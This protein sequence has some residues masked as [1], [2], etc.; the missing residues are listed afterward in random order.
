MSER[1]V[2]DPRSALQALLDVMQKLRAPSC[3]CPWDLQQT[4]ASIAPYTLE[5]AYEVVDAIQSGDPATLRDELGDLLFQVVFHARLAEEKRWFDFADVAQGVADKL[6]RRHPHVFAAT[7]AGN[8]AALNSAWEAAKAEERSA[9]GD[10]GVLAGVAKSLPALTRAQKLG[11]RASRV[12]FDWQD[13]SG[14][15]A[16]ITEELAELQAA[17]QSGEAA[18]RRSEEFGDLLFALTSYARHLGVDSEQ[19][20]AAASRKF[21]QRFALMEE[22]ARDRQLQL[23]A[24][25]P[26]QWDQ[27]WNESKVLLSSQSSAKNTTA[28][29]AAGTFS[30][31]SLPG[32]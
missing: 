10:G 18:E 15:H 25:T 4:F 31:D 27:L 8:Q 32:R 6:T 13:P 17:V 24:L 21:E 9:R 30:V 7:A 23:A 28:K 1:I 5:E 2:Q 29:H 12:G 11:K 26:L 20:L 19:A 14:A 3:G 22:L 16:K